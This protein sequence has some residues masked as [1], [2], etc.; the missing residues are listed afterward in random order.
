MSVGKILIVRCMSDNADAT[1][2]ADASLHSSVTDSRGNTYTKA[3]EWQFGTG[4]AGAGVTVSLWYCKVATALLENDLITLT[5][6]ISVTAKAIGATQFSI[7]GASVSLAGASG[8]VGTGT[9]PSVTLSGLPSA[10][11]LWLGVTGREGPTGDTVTADADYGFQ[12]DLIEGTS[13]GNALTNVSDDHGGYR[14]ATLTSDTY[15]PTLGTS[16]DYATI[17]VAIQEV[18]EITTAEMAAAARQPASHP[19]FKSP[20]RQEG[21]TVKSLLP[22]FDSATVIFPYLIPLFSRQIVSPAFIGFFAFI[23]VEAPAVPPSPPVPPIAPFSEFHLQVIV[24][25]DISEGY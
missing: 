18:V 19:L 15:N 24:L 14:V 13:G 12:A 21:A 16:R 10:E 2:D 17:L 8:V 6:A 23:S 22:V 5:L 11:Y 9:T 1:H 20:P 3:K 25:P 7:T 4:G